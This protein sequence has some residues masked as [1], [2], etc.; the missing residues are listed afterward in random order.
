[1]KYFTRTLYERFNSPNA[2]IADRADARWDAAAERYRTRLAA[3]RSQLPPTVRRLADE[4]YLH[5]AQIVNLVHVPDSLAIWARQGNRLYILSYRL[6]RPLTISDPIESPLYSRGRAFWLYD[7]IDRPR[8]GVFT[9]KI[10]LSDGRELKI[11]FDQLDI[12]DF[13]LHPPGTAE[14]L[15]ALKELRSIAEQIAESASEKLSLANRSDPKMRLEELASAARQAAGR[16]PRPR[17]L[18][19]VF[20]AHPLFGPVP[21]SKSRK[22]NAKKRAPI[23]RRDTERRGAASPNAPSKKPER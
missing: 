10:L 22:S 5:D 16:E 13:E 12:V 8:Q 7:E 9:H 6:L 3:I 14:Q 23:P 4:I 2:S 19:A 20:P 15:D 17:G 21:V 11:V 18:D 1:M